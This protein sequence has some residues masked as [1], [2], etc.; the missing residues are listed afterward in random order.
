MAQALRHM[1]LPQRPQ[2]MAQAPRHMEIKCGSWLA[3][4]GGV[5]VDE[6]VN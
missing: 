6:L 1:E 5:S 4:E 3:S 2:G